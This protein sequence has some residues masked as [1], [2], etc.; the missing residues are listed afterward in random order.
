V[1]GV[2]GSLLYGLGPRDVSTFAGAAAVLVALGTLA[3]WL[4]ARRAA[5]TNPAETLRMS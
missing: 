4:P 1:S 5:E 2:V 3:A